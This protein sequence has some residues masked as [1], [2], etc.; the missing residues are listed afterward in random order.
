VPRVRIELTS[1][2]FQTTAVT[3]LATSAIGDILT[4]LGLGIFNNLS[5]RLVFFGRQ[6]LTFCF[7]KTLDS[8]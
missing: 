8:H 1:E 6:N 3:D 7:L 4:Q 5:H 2:V